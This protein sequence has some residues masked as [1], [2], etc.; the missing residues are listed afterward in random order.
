MPYV[1]PRWKIEVR[2]TVHPPYEWAT[3][4]R[5]EGH[6]YAFVEKHEAETA[7]VKLKAIQPHA[8]LRVSP[9]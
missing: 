3:V 5:D 2:A 1:K 7:L 8:V 9:A 6:A 4:Y